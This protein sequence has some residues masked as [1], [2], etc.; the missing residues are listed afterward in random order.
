MPV[1]GITKIQ[2]RVLE[3]LADSQGARPHEFNSF[4]SR[5][6]FHSPG[7]TFTDVMADQSYRK[8]DSLL[9]RCPVLRSAEWKRPISFSR[10]IRISQP[11]IFGG[12]FWLRYMNPRRRKRAITSSYVYLKRIGIQWVFEFRT[13]FLKVTQSY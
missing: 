7:A 3:H 1:G 2:P 4:A 12:N 8:L 11:S 6:E 13:Q 5:Y 10:A 9:T